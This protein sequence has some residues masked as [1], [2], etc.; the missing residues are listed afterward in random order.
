MI[1]SIK[2]PPPNTTQIIPPNRSLDTREP[3]VS[4][5]ACL[6]HQKVVE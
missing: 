3:E 6:D 5:L 4:F 2:Q 1:V